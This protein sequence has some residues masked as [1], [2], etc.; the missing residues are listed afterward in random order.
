MLQ[1][2]KWEPA[3]IILQSIETA[4]THSSNPMAKESLLEAVIEILH[5][6]AN[7]LQSSRTMGEATSLYLGRDNSFLHELT[8]WLLD[9]IEMAKFILMPVGGFQFWSTDEAIEYST[10]VVAVIKDLETAAIPYRAHSAT[11]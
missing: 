4:R 11:S 9:V 7:P 1:L 6:Y 10:L 3:Q 5:I 8:P 2:I